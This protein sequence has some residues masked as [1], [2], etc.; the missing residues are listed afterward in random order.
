MAQLPHKPFI[1]DLTSQIDR[2]SD[3]DTTLHHG[4]MVNNKADLFH[5]NLPVHRS[6]HALD[7][8]ISDDNIRR[9]LQA[10]TD[11]GACIGMPTH[12]HQEQLLHATSYKELLTFTYLI[13]DVVIKTFLKITY[14]NNPTLQY[15]PSYF[16]YDLA[17]KGWAH[18]FPSYSYSEDSI[19]RLNR[20]KP[21]LNTST[22]IIPIHVHG[23]LLYIL[24][25]SNKSLYDN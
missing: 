12:T 21:T 23:N 3:E 7:H 5:S 8:D 19:S 18:T 15:I 13:N 6:N 17:R 24:A 11:Q 1:I 25:L 14:Q 4:L 16:F 9:I 10:Y 22:L 2:S 20:S